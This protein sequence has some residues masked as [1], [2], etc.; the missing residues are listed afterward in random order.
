MPPAAAVSPPVKMPGSPMASTASAT[1]WASRCPKPSSGTLAPAPANSA[2]G[3][4]RPSPLST[5]PATT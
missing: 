4:Y 2:S 3:W 5:T 1:P